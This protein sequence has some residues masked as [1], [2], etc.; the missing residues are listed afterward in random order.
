MVFLTSR[1]S[2]PRLDTPRTF[3][4]D[5]SILKFSAGQPHPEARESKIHVLNSRWE[6]PAIGIEIVGDHI[7]LVLYYLNAAS[8]EDHV[9]IWEWR[10]GVLKTVC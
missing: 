6:K 9:F 7:V 2:T 8:P 5:L 1:T 4:I 3:D 10:T